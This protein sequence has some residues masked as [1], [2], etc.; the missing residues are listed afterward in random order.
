MSTTTAICEHPAAAR[1]WDIDEMRCRNCGQSI[2]YPPRLPSAEDARDRRRDARIVSGEHH[3]RTYA[4]VQ[5]QEVVEVE[6][7]VQEHGVQPL[8]EADTQAST[9]LLPCHCCKQMLPP[10]NFYADNSAKAA[11]RLFRAPRCRPCTSF[12]LRIERERN[13][14]A[15]RRRDRVRAE[16][17]REKARAEGRA[18][19]ATKASTAANTL[20]SQR[21]RARLDGR[22]VP[23]QRPGRLPV[24][25]KPICKIFAGCPLRKYCTVESKNLA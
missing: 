21:Y 7:G 18:P 20:A 23:L 2:S 5:E 14:E 22:A 6:H 19:T 8:Q 11:K 16:G 10:D 25:L 13:P 15:I 4:P 1:F 9:Q 12:R 3:R 17:Y 24:F